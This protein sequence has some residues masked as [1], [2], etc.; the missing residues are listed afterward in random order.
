MAKTA[1]TAAAGPVENFRANVPLIRTLVT[2]GSILLSVGWL[3]WQGSQWVSRIETRLSAIETIATEKASKSEAESIRRETE[4]RFELLCAR[5]PN[6]HK[7]W[8][9]GELEGLRA[10]S[11]RRPP[12]AVKAGG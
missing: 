1:A 12:V 8:V 11:P 6:A 9:C 7:S 4:H 10:A 2:A 5:A 3:T